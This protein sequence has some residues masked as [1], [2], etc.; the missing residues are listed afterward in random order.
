MAKSKA[1]SGLSI[2]RNNNN[3]TFAWSKPQEYDVQGLMYH[4]NWK[5]VE[6]FTLD[7]NATSKVIT[8]DLKNYYPKKKDTYLKNIKFNIHAKKNNE[9]VSDWAP[10]EYLVSPPP[11]PKL[12]A[13]LSNEFEH[14]TTFSWNINW[15][16]SS[17]A[18]SPNI[19][20]NYKWWT[21]LKKD[22]NLA[23]EK[24]K[25]WTES[26]VT[27]DGADSGSK[28]I[29]ETQIFS[30]NYSYTRYFKIQARGPAGNSKVAYAKHVYAFP[31]APKNVKASVTKLKSGSGHRVSVSWTA[32]ST[33]ARPIDSIMVQ[34]SIGIPDSSYTDSGT[35]RKTTLT[36]PTIDSWTTA[37]VVKDTKDKKG[38]VDGAAFIING[39]N[40]SNDSWIFVRVVAKHDNLES[41]SSVVFATDGA[42][43]LSA[44]SGFSSTEGEDKIVTISLTNTCSITASFVGIFYRNPHISRPLLIGIYP[45]GRSAD[46]TVQLPLNWG[47]TEYSLGIQTFVADYSPNRQYDHGVTV[48]YL[49]DIRM[50]SSGILWDER[51]VPKPPSNI[52]LSSPRSGV[53]RVT[54]DWSW[55][56][57]NGVELSWANHDDA[58]ES[59]DT[60]TTYVLEN[61]RATAWN[62][63]GLDVGEWYVRVR[64]FKMDGENVAYGVYSDIHT[65]KIATT[66]DTPVLTLSDSI[67]PP[68]GTLTCY[69]A[70]TATDNDNQAYAEIRE[71]ILDNN[72]VPTDYIDI[73][74]RTENEQY[75]SI[76]I[77]SLGWLAGSKHYLSVRV[78]TGSGEGGE[79]WSTPKPVQILE[80]ITAE[81]TSTSLANVTVID[82]PDQ[83]I[84]HTQ[85]SLTDLPLAVTATGAGDSGLMTYIIER[86]D[87][88][89]L[90]RPDES[91]VSGYQGETIAIIQQTPNSIYTATADIIVASDKAYYTKSG[92]EYTEVTPEGTENPSQE[93]WYEISSYDYS[94]VIG[95]V[96]LLGPLDDNAAYNLIAIAQDSYGQ[97]ATAPV[98]R[99]EVHWSHKAVKPSGIISVDNDEMVA[100]ITPTQPL[101]GYAQGDTCDIY[102]LSVDRP[103]LIVQDAVF[104]TMYVDPFPT[105]GNMGGHRLVY[106]TSTGSYITNTN[107]EFAWTDY[108]V[109]ENDIVDRFATVVDFGKDRVILPYDL[110]LSSKWSKD[111]TMTKYLGGSVK[112]DWN[113]AIERTGSVKTRVAVEYD[114]ELIESMR[115]LANYAGI[116]HIRMPDG[117][118]FA[119]NV[120]VTEDRE[121]KKINMIA[122]FT[123]E[124][125]KVDSEGFDG[126]LYSEWLEDT[127]T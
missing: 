34:Y 42:G 72:G 80:P 26:G 99:F 82:D 19:F 27:N 37:C 55:Q 111:F 126:M 2:T 53:I 23:P 90:E 3:F 29:N 94:A 60:P 121:E 20:T 54:W 123:L 56:D 102:R 38:D 33:L 43:E 103:E 13:T 108:G 127:T 15:G 124:I 30:G 95:M 81:I 71:A 66:P 31:N 79:N 45:A 44:P 119:A 41:P 5:Y 1:P 4:V 35:V 57:A 46:L 62:I 100:F 106:K 85:L 22:S 25:G 39:A 83:S 8:H 58:W 24:I 75:K 76:D 47:D 116:C 59:T 36:A 77:A 115:R 93:G 64:L 65:I 10:K 74:M 78:I 49:T 73:G 87:D 51:P 101:S 69:W 40:I 17:K 67:V 114:S 21:V 48:Y 98:V 9:E 107:R 7:K 109:D 110:S 32:A 6:S 89:H 18:A 112:G 91:E 52:N 88:Y 125:T 97:T 92:D 104:G 11:K 16:S 86:A 122:S 96:D 118:S 70:F 63:A 120:N 105:L 84:S 14:T 117:S 68:D 28:T 61:T 113:P 12:T 50:S